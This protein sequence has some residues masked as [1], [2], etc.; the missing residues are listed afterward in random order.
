MLQLERLVDEDGYQLD[1]PEAGDE[2][3]DGDRDG[4]TLLQDGFETRLCPVVFEEVAEHTAGEP[5][6]DVVGGVH[7]GQPS[8][9]QV[10]D[11]PSMGVPANSSVFKSVPDV[12][13]TP[14]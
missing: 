13:P 12:V 9:P 1:R 7:G 11:T 8:M 2:E 3:E 6:G 4:P 14:G 10:S 5:E